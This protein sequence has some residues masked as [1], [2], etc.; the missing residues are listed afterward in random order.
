MKDLSRSLPELQ[1]Q[2]HDIA[3]KNGFWDT[4]SLYYDTPEVLH[5]DVTTKLALIADEAHEALSELRSHEFDQ[6]AAD[7][8]NYTG[9]LPPEFGEE[10]ADIVI[11]TLD[12]AEGLRI[13]LESYIVAK[14][15]KNRGRPR[16]H[17][18]NF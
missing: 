8:G 17:G 16:K 4:F 11:R 10:L 15:D 14:I 9:Q 13:D 2:A 18:K 5:R 3:N 7:S 12:L 1:K 6:A